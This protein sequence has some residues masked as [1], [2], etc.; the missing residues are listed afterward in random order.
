MALVAL[1]GLH[2][3]FRQ[4]SAP[5]V[6]AVNG[7][8]LSIDRGETLALIGES[9]SGK[10]T[11][12]RLALGLIEP[13]RGEVIVDGRDLAA[14]DRRSL[15]R[16]RKDMTVVF[17]EP[18][19]SLNPLMTVGQTIEEP[20]LIHE[21]TLDRDER[22]R[23]VIETMELVIL[24]SRL[25][26]RRSGALSGGQQQRVGIA[27]AIVTHPKFVVLDE[28]T[29]SLD[30]SVQAGILA[31]LARLQSELGLAYL[32]ISHDIQTVDFFSDRAA[33]MYLGQIVEIGPKTAVLDHPRHPYTEALLSSS[34]SA[35]PDEKLPSA[36]LMGDIPS[37]TSLP[38]GCF[39]YSR[40]PYRGD[41]R[42]ESERPPLREVGPGHLVATFCEIDFEREPRSIGVEGP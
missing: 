23:R 29:S 8:T 25:Y 3:A 22:R 6:Q 12:G 35:D 26:D 17:Q 13:D 7:V 28:P 11:L 36:R 41:P 2:K 10:S 15:Q 31:L 19:L 39:F 37:P 9:G 4:G 40:C 32:F 38:A 30:L 5:S 16:A 24:A 18:R 34:L 21:P 20:L 14:L 27:R 33:V 1:T 42:C